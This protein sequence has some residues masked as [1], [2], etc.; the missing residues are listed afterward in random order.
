MGGGA[1]YYELERGDDFSTFFVICILIGIYGLICVHYSNIIHFVFAFVVFI[2]ILFFMIRH[3]YLQN[4]IVLLSSLFLQILLFIQI[5][6]SVILNKNI[7]ISETIYI[8]NFAFYYLY[9]HVL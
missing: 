1:L 4:N 6:F 3:Y 5:L 9:L 7:F 8:I 2:F